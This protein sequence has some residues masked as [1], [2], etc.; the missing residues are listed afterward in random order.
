MEFPQ[1]ESIGSIYLSNLDVTLSNLGVRGTQG[2][3]NFNHPDYPDHPV[4]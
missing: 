1:R 3:R 4:T 2:D